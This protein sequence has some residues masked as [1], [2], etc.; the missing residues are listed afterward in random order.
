M[1]RHNWATHLAIAVETAKSKTFQWG[2]FD[3]MLFAADVVYAMTG[4]DYAKEFRGTYDSEFGAYRLIAAYGSEADLLTRVIG[5]SSV[6]SSQG[7]RGDVVLAS[8]P[9]PT[10]GVC[11]G[12]NCAFLASGEKGIIFLP[13]SVITQVWRIE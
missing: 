8:L 2:T 4:V 5:V 3:C 10:V 11:M 9:T 12:V 6:Q 7:M 13:R 1:R